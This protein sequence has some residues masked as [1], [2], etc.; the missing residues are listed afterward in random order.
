MGAQWWTDYQPVSYQI[1]SKRGNRTQFENM[2]QA[3][4]AA[5]VGVLVDAVL[6]H[7][8]GTESGVGVAGSCT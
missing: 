1:I 2:V 4:K 7:M 3:C 5:G 8:T 6:N